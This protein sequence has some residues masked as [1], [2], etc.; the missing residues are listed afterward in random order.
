MNTNV[1][2]R[3]FGGGSMDLLDLQPTHKL[4]NA[5]DFAETPGTI[6]VLPKPGT[7]T[8][9]AYG[10]IKVTKERNQRFVDNFTAKVYQDKV[11]IDIEHQPQLS[12]AV[13]WITGLTLNEDGSVDGT[14]DWSERG[15]QAID[16]DRFKYFSPSWF[17]NWQEP[18]SGKKYKDVLI[19]GAITTRPFFKDQSLKPLV[20]SELVPSTDDED[21]NDWQ[22]QEYA[23]IPAGMS[24][25]EMRNAVSTAIRATY[26]PANPKN[27]SAYYIYVAD[28]FSDFAIFCDESASPY[29]YKKIDYSID[30]TGAVTLSGAPVDVQRYTAWRV[31]GA[32]VPKKASEDNPV[33]AGMN[34]KKCAGC[35]AMC[36]DDDTK[37]AS[38]GAKLTAERE[39]DV[40]ITKEELAAFFSENPN[41]ISDLPVV[42][43]LTTQVTELKAANEG[44]ATQLEANKAALTA[45]EGKVATLEANARKRGLTDLVEGRPAYGFG[46]GYR[47]YGDVEKNVATLDTMLTTFG[48][49]SDQFKD[50]VNNMRTTAEQLRKAGLF[51]ESGKDTPQ[52]TA[53]GAASGELDAAVKVYMEAN[54]GTDEPT[55]MNKVLEANPKL[56]S[57]YQKRQ[58]LLQKRGED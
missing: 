16:E 26:Q 35:G 39:P 43:D 34:K 11:P 29:Q 17:D 12:G 4:F 13:G 41:I 58:T 48:E 14:V 10:K 44:Y 30:K 20:A 38:C 23:E 51:S 54:P 2:G 45:S 32:G 42:K 36:A 9:P 27:N 31:V 37:C 21:G 24:I 3:L 50:Y 49:D 57:E 53:A 22:L 28:V 52:S 56:Y 1:L 7:Y 46:E 40:S 15:T 19:G 8:H 25:D 5:I 33:D 55:A 18:L 6:N 47:W